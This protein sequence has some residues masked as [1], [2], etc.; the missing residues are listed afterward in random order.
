M[1]LDSHQMD[2][3]KSGTSPKSENF[4]ALVLTREGAT[5]FFDPYRVGPYAIGRMEVRVGRSIIEPLAPGIRESYGEV[6]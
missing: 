4:Q 6:G 2:W 5:I 1:T 3:L